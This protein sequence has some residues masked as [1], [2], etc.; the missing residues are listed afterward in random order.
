MQRR[1]GGGAHRLGGAGAGLPRRQVHQIA[2]G[3]LPFG[4]GQPD[5]H[6]IE[7]WDPGAQCDVIGHVAKLR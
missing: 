3:A 6:H 7:R 5:I 4:G 1:G 2:V